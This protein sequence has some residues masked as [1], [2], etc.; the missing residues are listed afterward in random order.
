M[1]HARK[2]ALL[3]IKK[4]KKSRQ[5]ETAAVDLFFSYPALHTF[6]SHSK[7]AAAVVIPHC[8]RRATRE[9]LSPNTLPTISTVSLL[10]T[11]IGMSK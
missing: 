6:Q 7:A 4:K 9:Y 8:C 2:R 10:F 5:I 3:Q 11:A 1:L